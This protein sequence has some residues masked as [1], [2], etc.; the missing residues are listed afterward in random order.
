MSN[1]NAQHHQVTAPAA[2]LVAGGP[3]SGKSTAAQ[4][5]RERG[6]DSVDLD[7]GYARWEDADGSPVP[8][9]AEP[10]RGWLDA[11]RW[12]WQVDLLDAA[13]ADRG[14]GPTVFTG[15]AR[16]MFELLDRFDL[17][18]L[19]RMDDATRRTRL[20][21]PQRANVFG[22]VGDTAA[23][24]AWWHK[25]VEDELL[26]RRTQVIDAAEPIDSVVADILR[27]LNR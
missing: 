13:L 25:T 16:N 27:C 23:W 20:A 4:V 2:I 17:V 6:V 11:H 19:L 8:F 22:R 7:F 10:T 5:L 24:S 15:T 14:S 9:P 3:G 1:D 12:Q 18:L 26:K 21:D